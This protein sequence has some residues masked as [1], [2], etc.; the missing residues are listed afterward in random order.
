MLA[1]LTTALGSWAAWWPACLAGMAS[2]WRAAQPCFGPQ[3]TTHPHPPLPGRMND[4]QNMFEDHLAHQVSNCFQ[5]L[6]CCATPSV[7]VVCLPRHHVPAGCGVLLLGH[8]GI[9]ALSNF[10]SK[11]APA[12]FPTPPAN[13]LPGCCREQHGTS[14]G[15]TWDGLAPRPASHSAVVAAVV[16]AVVASRTCSAWLHC[17]PLAASASASLATSRAINCCGAATVRR[18]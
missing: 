4:G 11:P 16:P 12:G 2:G 1:V 15:C 7:A 13:L 14:G 5:C 17:C 9:A 10:Y 6:L 8:C 3:L 18:T